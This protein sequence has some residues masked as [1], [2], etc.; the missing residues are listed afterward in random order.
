MEKD[1]LTYLNDIFADNIQK[2][3]ISNLSNKDYIYKKIEI[4][5]VKDKYLVSQY[6]QTQVFNKNLSQKN[7]FDFLSDCCQNFKQFNFFGDTNEYSMKFSKKNKLFFNKTKFHSLAKVQTENNRKKNYLL[8]EYDDIPPLVDIGVFTKEGKIV[9]SMQNK[10]KQ[11]NRFL[12]II[13]D[14]IKDKHLT[15]INIIDF[16]CGKSYLTFI[17]YYYFKFIK[18]IQPNI[19]GLDLKTD[20]I[21]HCNKTAEKYGYDGLKFE[22]GN[23]NGYTPSVKPDMVVTLHA[24]DTATD[25]ALFNAINWGAKMIFSVP[26]CQHEVNSQINSDNFSIITR[27]G[28]VKERISALFTDTIRCNLLGV[29]SYKVDLIELVDLSHSPKN[30]LIRANK[31]NISSATKK[32]KLQEVENL[33]KEFNFNQKLYDLLQ[34]QIKIN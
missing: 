16:G 11:I 21:A 22:V 14:S 31:T 29:I 30:L 27:Y 15:E 33:K 2:I 25:Y 7:L 34:N 3:V 4:K 28:I 10:F 19:I 9:A 8:N 12:E 18:N 23:I 17:I 26:C 5:K 13:D 24:C 32:S 20:V 1:F 6:S